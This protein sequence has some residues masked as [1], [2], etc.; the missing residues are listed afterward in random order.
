MSSVGF[1]VPPYLDIGQGL[2]VGGYDGEI[3]VANRIQFGGAEANL[4]RSLAYYDKFKFNLLAG[5]RYVDLDEQMDIVSKT[6]DP[7]IAVDPIGD[8]DVTIRLA[9]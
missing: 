1:G 5:I 4:L 6:V 7:R 9:Q 8:P 2:G 3:H